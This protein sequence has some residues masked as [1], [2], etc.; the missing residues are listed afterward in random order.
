MA[1][2]PSEPTNA[3]LY[4]VEPDA[5][6]HRCD[7]AALPLHTTADLQ[8]LAETLGQERAL[9]A[10][11]LGVGVRHEGYNLYVMGSPG[12]GKHSIV[13]EM[14]E[15]SATGVVALSD[16]CYVNNFRTPYRPR[17]LR[18]PTGT[19]NALQRDMRG[20]LRALMTALPAAFDSDDYRNRAQEIHDEFKARE[21]RAFAEVGE[22][23][24]QAQIMLMRTPMGYTI[25][26]VKN[27]EVLGPEEFE[28]LTDEEKQTIERN[29]NELR[30]SLGRVL[31]QAA[32]WHREH[33][34]RVE[35]LDAEITR[36]TI[37]RLMADV[38]ARYRSQSDIA[39]YLA[40][41]KQDIIDNGDDIRRF[42]AEQKPH[43]EPQTRLT[44][45]NRYAVNVLVDNSDT[46]GAP[47]IYEDNPTY[48]NLVGRIE[49]VAQMGALL[50]DFTLI[51]SGALHRA[52][53]GYL[54]LDARKVL[55]TPFAWDAVKRAMQAHELR[56][57]SLDQMLS[58]ATTMSLEPDAIPLDVKIVL[59]G[60]RLLYYLL[61]QYDPEFALLFK[62]EADFAEDLPRSAEN[63]LL[64][65]RLV[66]TLQRADK[67]RP[68]DRDAVARVIE[69]AARRADDSQRLSLQTEGLR[70]VLRES[71]YWAGQVGSDVIRGGD[72]E[73]AIGERIH[74]ADQ[75]RERMQDSILRD[76]RLIDTAGSRVAQI[77]GL[78]V[79]QLG[80]Y[81][82]GLP[83]RIT[84]TARLGDGKFVDIERE[85]QLGGAIHSKGV[86]ILSSY[87]SGRFSR[88]EPLSLA[89]SLV[90]EQSYGGVDGDS[91]SMAELCVLQSALCE[92]PL[93]QDLAITGSVNQHGQT[94]AIGGVNEK[95]EGFFD[96]CRARGLSGTQGVIIP[97]GNVQ[98]L[99]LR[100][101]IVGAVR[102][103]RFA[104]YAV[105]HVDQAMELLSG[106]AAGIADAHG[107]FPDGSVNGLVQ[108]RLRELT[109]LR[110]RYAHPDKGN[111]KESDKENDRENDKGSNRTEGNGDD[112]SK[113]KANAADTIA[114]GGDRKASQ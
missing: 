57:Q 79:T 43:G 82:F 16:W 26:P 113:D 97:A 39:A 24:R 3:T 9:G 81:A 61:N 86:L 50:T 11:R 23:A 34:Q 65:A 112:K 93:R 19:G 110:Q 28:K 74:R 33:D 101:D 29:S 114:S 7:P 67:L 48:Q 98:H 35:Q 13:R 96:V 68:L 4:E 84:A 88:D 76:M 69:H 17:V 100:Q 51:K 10:L 2:K 102:D 71:D 111:E 25:A 49:H 40:D 85:V 73:R 92:L 64:Y 12:L 21:E 6:Y 52:N 59:I 66:A 36:A 44:P 38:E 104:V 56:V 89:A 54:I 103:K 78:V 75:I 95:I 109:A 91:A 99:M 72:V 1:C 37:D 45:F 77:N 60:D 94:Q 58:L 80:A 83:S 46:R 20:L 90:F 62:V 41:V 53:G 55:S 105:A 107:V 30:R 8:D 5:L 70:D 87:L 63:T 32:G 22:R 31:Q 18:L 106:R 14:L 108:R 42:A 27:G 15:R 47:V